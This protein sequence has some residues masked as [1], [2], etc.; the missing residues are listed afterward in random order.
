MA[1]APLPPR[2]LSPDALATL[3][4]ERLSALAAEGDDLA[5]AAIV[6]RHS[7]GLLRYC[8]RLAPHEQAED[9]LQ[10]TLLSAYRALRNGHGPTDLRPWLFAIARNAAVDQ[11]R[12]AW[13]DLAPYTAEADPREA[14][15]PVERREL[16]GNLVD[17]LGALPDRQRQ[18]IVLRVLEDRSYEE[19]AGRFDMS[20][21]SARQLI[22]RTRRSLRSGWAA[23]V[24][25]LWWL[26]DLFTRAAVTPAAEIGG[27]ATAG[28]AKVAALVTVTGAV[29]A[30]TAVDDLKLPAKHEAAVQA[31]T[32]P[33]LGR[34]GDA[35]ASQSFGAA[36]PIA[37]AMASP[38]DE[39]VAAALG[40]DS[41][42]AVLNALLVFEDGGVVPQAILP[43]DLAPAPA[44]TPSDATPAEEVPGLEPIAPV[45]VE[46][47]APASEE[48]TS[49]P[50]TAFEDDGSGP[51]D[52]E[53]PEPA[54][55]EEPVA[56]DDTGGEV[57][58]E[59][60]EASEG[61]GEPSSGAPAE[62][63]EDAGAPLGT[64]E[65]AA[66][67]P[68]PAEPTPSPEP[69]PTEGGAP[70]DSGSEPP[71]EP[72]PEPTPE[73]SPTPGSDAAQPG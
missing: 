53:K 71:A 52:E 42:Q 73:P 23:A 69:A 33:A 66:E 34:A 9:A 36:A 51:V 6:S 72:A 19:I 20:E 32:A 44:N 45:D 70:A 68:A 30:G 67:E 5:F 35:S 17:A 59:D 24:A 27:Q 15:D 57:V 60:P 31:Q 8:R 63:T 29:A 2:V 62:P 49:G 43:A 47:T 22:H 39:R 41:G 28:A 21:R 3:P 18:A 50:G 10:T 26:R 4:D 55:I 48:P 58:I 25:P 12:S 13:P 38:M 11:R 1:I 37:L 46:P 14:I 65:Q 56:E 7:P 40:V 61:T 54:P 64:G 16:L